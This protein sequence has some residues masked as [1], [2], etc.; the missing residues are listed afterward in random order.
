MLEILKGFGDVFWN[1]D[2]YIVQVI[3]PVYCQTAIVTA[4]PVGG[5]VK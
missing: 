2:I 4:F 3:A 5:D 1:G